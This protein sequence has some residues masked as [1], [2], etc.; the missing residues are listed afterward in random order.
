MDVS[1]QK[2]EP[3]EVKLLRE[4]EIEKGHHLCQSY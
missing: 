2:Q 1:G 3:L 4:P